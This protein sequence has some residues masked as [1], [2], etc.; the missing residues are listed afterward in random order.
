MDAAEVQE[1]VH[2]V[3]R[4][5]KRLHFAGGLMRV[6]SAQ[7][8]LRQLLLFRGLTDQDF[9]KVCLPKPCLPKH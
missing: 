9:A 3:D 7:H 2:L 5:K 4:Q 8:E 6:Q 1:V